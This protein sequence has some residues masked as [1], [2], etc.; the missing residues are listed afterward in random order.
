[1]QAPGRVLTKRYSPGPKG[2]T[3]R[4]YDKA[5]SFLTQQV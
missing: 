4:S 5:K 3:K 1:L 2:I